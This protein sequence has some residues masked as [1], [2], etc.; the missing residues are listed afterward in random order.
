M[1]TDWMLRLGV[2]GAAHGIAAGALLARIVGAHDDART[3]PTLDGADQS[4]VWALAPLAALGAASIPVVGVVGALVCAGAQLALVP[5]VVRD[6]ERIRWIGSVGRDLVLGPVVAGV[7]PFTSGIPVEAG[8]YDA[9][10][11]RPYRGAES[12]PL[13][14]VS[15]DSSRAVASVRRRLWCVSA[16][17]G[18][19]TTVAATCLLWR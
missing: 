14:L 13:A 19:S 1:D 11:G 8:V 9:A 18:V 5:A 4:L 3:R 16:T 10:A 7:L 12:A 2:L 15:R 17:M 6:V